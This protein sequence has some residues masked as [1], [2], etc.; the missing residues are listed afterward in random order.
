ML[1]SRRRRDW[2]PPAIFQEFPERELTKLTEPLPPTVLSFLSVPVLPASKIKG[3]FLR[4]RFVRG[5]DAALPRAAVF[6]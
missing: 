2:N 1:A 4:S 6:S 5:R 3:P